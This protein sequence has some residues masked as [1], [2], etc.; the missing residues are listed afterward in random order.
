MYF[1]DFGMYIKGKGERLYFVE[2]FV[3]FVEN[4][5]ENV[6]RVTLLKV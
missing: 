6:E 2:N 1:F 5:C 4:L 3:H